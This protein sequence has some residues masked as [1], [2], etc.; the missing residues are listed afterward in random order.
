MVA[1][2]CAPARTA[3]HI[4]KEARTAF[5][6]WGLLFLKR[7]LYSGAYP[8]GGSSQPNEANGGQEPSTAV[9]PASVTYTEQH[10]E[11]PAP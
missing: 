6:M 1:L 3:A 2:L 9:G 7:L 11:E 5:G 10:I 4:Y 8:V